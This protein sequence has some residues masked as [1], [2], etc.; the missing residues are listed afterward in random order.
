LLIALALGACGDAGRAH[1]DWVRRADAICASSNAQVRA[2]P[3]PQSLAATATFAASA[4]AIVRREAAA[5]GA[6]PGDPAD[7]ATLRRLRAALA[8]VVAVADG[9][10]VVARSGT[11]ADVEAYVT[12]SRG[13][14]TAADGLARALGLLVC[15]HAGG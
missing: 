15:G 3:R 7:A 5:I 10:A 13:S 6:L 9:L 14:S 12:A 8:H 1:A 2:L 4:A 11:A